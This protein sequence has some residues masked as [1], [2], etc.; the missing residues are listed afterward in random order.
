MA[1]IWML[2]STHMNTHVHGTHMNPHIWTPING[3]HMNSHVHGTHM[4]THKRKGSSKS[5]RSHMKR[6]S[7]PSLTCINE[8]G[9]SCMNESWHTYQ[10]VMA[11]IAM[12][13]DTHINACHQTRHS[14][15]SMSHGTRM[16]ESCPSYQSVICPTYEWVMANISTSHGTRLNESW[17]TYQRVT[18]CVRMNHVHHINGYEW[19][20]SH[21]NES[22]P[23]WMSHAPYEWVMSHMNASCRIWIMSIISISHMSHV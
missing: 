23:I 2:I 12:S 6:T 1:H 10:W 19:V 15:V 21:M 3:T 11:H 5:G 8:S 14:P 16:N 20:M 22:C 9:V 18:V 7:D 17:Q 4:N 13:P